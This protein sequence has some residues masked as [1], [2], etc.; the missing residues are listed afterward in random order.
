MKKTSLNIAV[1]TQLAQA[2]E[3]SNMLK[4]AQVTYIF[5]VFWILWTNCRPFI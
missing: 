4:P 2:T 1:H 5:Y 3:N